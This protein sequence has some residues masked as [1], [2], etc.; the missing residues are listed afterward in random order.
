MNTK[1]IKASMYKIMTFN[2]VNGSS[3]DILG[4]KLLCNA[5]FK[6]RF[7]VVSLHCK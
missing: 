2:W 1:V 6:M 7:S 4:H 3:C 5:G